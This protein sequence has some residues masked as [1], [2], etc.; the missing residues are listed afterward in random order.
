VAVG[1]LATSVVALFGSLYYSFKEVAPGA[2]I[3]GP[4]RVVPA[5]AIAALLAAAS[6]A[7]VLRHR[8]QEVWHA[9]GAVFE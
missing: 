1:A 9:M 2:G 3:P 8:R 5:L 4:Y 7:G 6:A